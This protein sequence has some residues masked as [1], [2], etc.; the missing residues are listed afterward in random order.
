MEVRQRGSVS[1][2][3]GFENFVSQ[4]KVTIN[5]RTQDDVI[6]VTLLRDTGAVQSLI[7]ESALPQGM[8]IDKGEYVL[9]GGFPDT[10][11]SC[12]LVEVFLDCN[13]VKGHCKL[14]V[15]PCLPIA[16][17]DVLLANDLAGGQVSV[18]PCVTCLP[19]EGTSDPL[20]GQALPV[21]V[22]TR[23]RAKANDQDKPDFDLCDSWLT[24]SLEGRTDLDEVQ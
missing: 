3:K 16:G 18:N 4:G 2:F 20:D 8:E 22:T 12:P 13:L 7:V 19:R 11:T 15:V 24:P 9:V 17:V 14:A 21:A 5:S 6:N 23:S 1:E 10:V